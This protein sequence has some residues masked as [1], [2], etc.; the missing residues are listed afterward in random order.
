MLVHVSYNII[1]K[2]SQYFKCNIYFFCL[3]FP[4]FPESKLMVCF[5][6]YFCWS[7]VVVYMDVWLHWI[8]AEFYCALEKTCSVISIWLFAYFAFLLCCR[9]FALFIFSAL[10]C[11][12]NLFKKNIKNVWPQIRSQSLGMNYFHWHWGMYLSVLGLISE[13]LL[14]F[15]NQKAQHF[16]GSWGHCK[17]ISIGGI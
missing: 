8:S 4:A 14:C 11:G 15:P 2:S 1:V 16:G 10:H 5:V 7:V 13:G 3:P 6:P 17:T 12:N 9:H